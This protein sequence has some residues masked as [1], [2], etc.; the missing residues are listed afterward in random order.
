[1]KPFIYITILLICSTVFS[2]DEKTK[3][4]FYTISLATTLAVNK[5][6]TI[7]EDDNGPLINPRALFVNNTLGYQLDKGNAVGIN[8]E[9]NWQPKQN[10][11]F[12]PL[13]VNLRHNIVVNDDNVFVRGGYGKL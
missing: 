4:F 13:Y 3:G 9:Y 1:L 6:D 11:H 12:F 2:Q 7:I 10:L 5:D 8:A